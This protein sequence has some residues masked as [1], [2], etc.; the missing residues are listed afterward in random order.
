M[1]SLVVDTVTSPVSANSSRKRAFLGEGPQR[2]A[3]PTINKTPSFQQ[4]DSNSTLLNDLDPNSK[5]RKA[6]KRKYFI[7]VVS[8]L[9][10]V[11]IVVGVSIGIFFAFAALEA[12]N[13]GSYYP[14]PFTGPV[15]VQD[16]ILLQLKTTSVDFQANRINYNL[17]VYPLG[18]YILNKE[19]MVSTT[20]ITLVMDNIER[21]FWVERGTINSPAQQNPFDFTVIANGSPIFYPFDKHTNNFTMYAYE[22]NNTE[23]VVPLFLDFRNIM[24]N[25]V[26]TT[27]YTFFGPSRA[28]ILAIVTV[29]RNAITQIFSIFTGLL[30]WVL[31]IAVSRFAVDAMTDTK[32][33]VEGPVMGVCIAMLFALPALRNTQPNIPPIGVLSD[34]FAFFWAELAIIFTA[35]TQVILYS[36]RKKKDAVSAAAAQAAIHDLEMNRKRK[37]KNGKDDDDGGAP[38]NAMDI[39]GDSGA[40]AAIV[41]GGELVGG[42]GDVGLDVPSDASF[43]DASFGDA[44]LDGAIS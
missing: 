15:N 29:S 13:Q 25:Y 30:M 36:I 3:L 4:K 34:V 37:G 7:W 11:L 27:S 2:W 8:A 41:G 40:S 17:R 10:A 14:T 18:K 16:G 12:R 31:G 26:V 42:G 19:I 33:Q 38:A 23:A 22:G 6:A 9:V 24:E 43:G 28:N 5:Y 35:L 20:P 39:W 1:P 32:K 44:P 21:K